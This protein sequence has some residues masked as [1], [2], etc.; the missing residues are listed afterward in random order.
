MSYNK[1]EYMKRWR[2]RNKEKIRAYNKKYYQKNYEKHSEKIRKQNLEHYHKHQGEIVKKQI[3]YK[4]KKY[5][6]DPVFKNKDNIRKYSAHTI[7]L[8]DK[9]CEICKS[10]KDLHRHH[11]TYDNKSKVRILCRRCHNQIHKPFERD[12]TPFIE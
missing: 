4:Q 3:E 10:N 8:K 12:K 6:N 9:E 1:K 11:E 2:E 7:S 5:L